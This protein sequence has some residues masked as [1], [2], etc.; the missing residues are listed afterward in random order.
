MTS[1][2]RER[3]CYKRN[4]LPR[5]HC[6]GAVTVNLRFRDRRRGAPVQLG[7]RPNIALFT[8]PPT[9]PSSTPT[10]QA[11]HRSGRVNLKQDLERAEAVGESISIAI[12]PN[13]HRAAPSRLEKIGALPGQSM[14]TL[15][16]A[17]VFTLALQTNEGGKSLLFYLHVFKHAS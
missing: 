2:R 8:H 16:V 9:R 14:V 4:K 12:H 10:R 5:V 3:G 11:F 13:Q 17:Q 7:T 15:K 6:C 1:R